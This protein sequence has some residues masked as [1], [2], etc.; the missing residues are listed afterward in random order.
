MCESLFRNRETN[1]YADTICYLRC[2][3]MWS[4]IKVQYMQ[5]HWMC[6]WTTNIE[7]QRYLKCVMIRNEIMRRDVKRNKNMLNIYHKHPSLLNPTEIIRD[8]SLIL[9]WNYS[10]YQFL[11]VPFKNMI[12]TDTWTNNIQPLT[13]HFSTKK[14]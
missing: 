14:K 6:M 5:F 9:E 3:N 2:A 13:T 11:T 4:A 12:Y 8:W 1:M 7:F 10:Y